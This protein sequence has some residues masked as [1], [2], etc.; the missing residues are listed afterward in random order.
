MPTG[1]N[2]FVAKWVASEFL[3]SIHKAG[4]FFDDP[5]KVIKIFSSLSSRMA[6]TPMT[7]NSSHARSIN[8]KWLYLHS[9][10]PSSSQR[11][12]AWILSGLSISTIT[13]WSGKCQSNHLSLKYLLRR[14]ILATQYGK[15]WNLSLAGVVCFLT[16]T[17]MF[18][19]PRSLAWS[20]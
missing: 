12:N 8:L 1:K 3:T 17:I 4:G 14:C 10:W 19:L 5:I 6:G 16:M 20:T 11:L 9:T 2:G 13:S 18:P 7:Y 15:S